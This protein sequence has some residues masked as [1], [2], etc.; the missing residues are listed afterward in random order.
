[1]KISVTDEAFVRHFGELGRSWGISRTA[2]QICALLYLSGQLLTADDI[3]DSLAISRSNTSMGLKELQSW[4]LVWLQRRPGDRREYF[5]TPKD[6]WEIMRIVAEER[7]RREIEPTLWMLRE[8][9]A[10][11]PVSLHDAMAQPRLREMLELFELLN[12]WLEGLGHEKSKKEV[13]FLK[14]SS[15]KNF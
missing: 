3:T 15:A 6:I 8:L 2:G 12:H 7:R 5:S 9:L 4:R 14:K 1:M 11:Q 13:A 10:E